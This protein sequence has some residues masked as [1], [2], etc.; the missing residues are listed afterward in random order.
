MFGRILKFGTK[1]A[2]CVQ[3]GSEAGN[4]I[5]EVIQAMSEQIERL[6]RTKVDVMPIVRA[7]ADSPSG[8]NSR[9]AA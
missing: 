5:A 8:L 9:R 2:L 7:S 4:D 3:L 1:K 6:E